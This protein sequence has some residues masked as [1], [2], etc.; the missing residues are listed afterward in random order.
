MSERPVSN[1]LALAVLACLAEEPMH[2][3]EMAATMRTRHKDD[4]IKLNYGSLYSVIESLCRHALIAPKETIRNGKRPERTIFELTPAGRNE[5]TEWL[6]D[7]LAEPA[8]EYTQFGA[9]LSLMP[10]LS[11]EEAIRLL[12]RRLEMIGLELAKAR[13]ID[14]YTRGKGVSRLHLIER[15]YEAMQREAE[16]RWVKALIADLES[17]KL[18]GIAEWR[19]W[20]KPGKASA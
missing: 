15:E 6:S 4:A 12:K 9:G 8:K 10:V 1:P 16:A 13:S 3:Y 19:T 7:L 17:G 14:A 18:E 11:P 5:L 20:H 2:P